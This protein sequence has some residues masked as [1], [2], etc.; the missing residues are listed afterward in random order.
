MDVFVR[1]RSL[2]TSTGGEAS[3]PRVLNRSR[4]RLDRLTT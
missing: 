3:E 4:K 2:V 1:H